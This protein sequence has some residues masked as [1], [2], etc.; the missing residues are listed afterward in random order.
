MHQLARGF[1]RLPAARAGKQSLVD[2]CDRRFHGEVSARGAI[3]AIRGLVAGRRRHRL[4][5]RDHR[6]AGEERGSLNR[7]FLPGV[8]FSSDRFRLFSRIFFFRRGGRGE[9]RRRSCATAARFLSFAS[10]SR[11]SNASSRRSSASWR[12]RACERESCTVTAIPLGRCRKVTAVETLLTCCPPGPEERAK[13]SSKSAAE[14]ASRRLRSA[15][16][17]VRPGNSTCPEIVVWFCRWPDSNRH[18]PLSPTDFKSVASA[19]S[20]HRRLLRRL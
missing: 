6:V 2:W 11:R 4:T 10:F 19:I 14:S 5:N 13:L 8:F 18:G 12:L 9:F 1:H 16:S 7:R 20:P 3:G 15:K 17:I